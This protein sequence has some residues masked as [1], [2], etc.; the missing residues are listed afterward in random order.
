MS[1]GQP[2]ADAMRQ[3]LGLVLDGAHGGIVLE[4]DRHDGRVS[5]S[6]AVSI[7]DEGD[8]R[9]EESIDLENN[10]RMSGE[11][12]KIEGKLRRAIGE[13]ERCRCVV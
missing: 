5:R 11:E 9:I 7:G 4:L 3:I 13:E 6:D 10:E 1:A 2:F 8:E 12:R